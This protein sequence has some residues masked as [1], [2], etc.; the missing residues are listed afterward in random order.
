MLTYWGNPETGEGV[1]AG[2]VWNTVN[3]YLFTA[4]DMADDVFGVINA[5][6]GQIAQITIEG[7]ADSI[8]GGQGDQFNNT[9]DGSVTVGDN[10]ADTGFDTGKDGDYTGNYQIRVT[11]LDGTVAETVVSLTQEQFEYLNGLL[12]DADGNSRL[13]EKEVAYQ[14]QA[15][16]AEG[17]PMVDADGNPILIDAVVEGDTI[18][19]NHPIILTPTQN[20]GGTEEIGK[21]SAADDFIVAGRLDLLHGAYIDGGEGNNTLEIDA[22]GYYAQPKELLNI[23]TINIENLPNVYTNDSGDSTYP[24]L[25]GNG[26]NDSTI[27]LSRA[28]DLEKLTITESDFDGVNEAELGTLTIAG[29]RNGA[30]TRFEGEFSQ[31][32]TVHY[33]E[34]LT[35]ALNIEL[36]IGDVNADINLLHNASTLNIDSQGTENHMHQFFAGGTLSH[37]NISGEAIFSVEENMAAGFNTDRPAVI[38]ASANTGGVDLTIDGHADEVIFTGTAE[39]DDQFQA[40]SNGKAVTINGGNGDN[41]FSATSGDVVTITAGSGNNTITTDDSDT[42][43]ITTGE[44]NDVI[45]SV[46]GE[47]VS[48]NAA[49]GDNSITVSADE[50][51]ITTGEGNDT[52][53]ISG[54][55]DTTG[56]NADGN[57]AALVNIDTGTGEDTVVLGRDLASF[58]FGI[59]A[60][61]GSSISGEN[62]TLYVENASDLRAAELSGVENVVLNFDVDGGILTLTDAQFAAIGA[63]NFAVEGAPFYTSAQVKIIVTESTSLTDLGVD[64]LPVGVDLILEIQDGVTLEMTAEQLHT[65]VAEQ[66]VTLANDNNGDQQS[67]SVLITNAGLDFDPFNS[68]DDARSIVDGVALSGGSL[69]SDF[70]EDGNDSNTTVDRNEWGQNVLI[71][72]NMNGYDRPADVP[73]YS[74]L[75][76]NTDE[77]S[78][79]GPFETIETFLRITGESDL[80]FTPVEGGVDDWGRPIE[81]GSAIALGVDNGV[82]TNGFIVD[83]SSVGGVVNNLTLSG[84]ENADAI[85]GNGARVNVELT[86][87]VGDDGTA[88]N[89]EGGLVSSG[90]HTYVVT[91]M[92]DGDREFWTCETTKDLETLGLRGNDNTTITFGNTERG[93][94]FLMEVVYDKQDGYAVGGL[95]AN[96]ARPEG[97]TAVVNVVGLDTLPAGEVQQV[98]GISTDATAAI[99]NIEGGNTVVESLSGANLTDLAVSAD[100]NLTIAGDLP[101]GLTSFDASGV[102]GDLAVT[103]DLWEAN[104]TPLTFE[105]AAGSTTLTIDDAADGAIASIMGAGEIALVIGD[106]NGSDSADL[107]G[108]ELSNITSVSLSENAQL[109]LTLDQAYTIGAENFSGEGSLTLTELNDQPFSRAD[110]E[111]DVTN[112]TLRVVEQSDVTLNSATDLTGITTLEVYEGTTLNLTAA[113]FQ[114]LNGSNGGIITVLDGSDEGTAVDLSTVTINITDLSQADLENGVLDT[115]AIT[116][117][118]INITTAESV[119]LV[120]ATNL[121]GVD[122]ITLADGTTLSVEALEE[123]DGIDVAGIDAIIKIL[124]ETIGATTSIDASGFD[125]SQIYLANT[126]LQNGVNV[127]ALLAG[128]PFTVEKVIFNGEGL[129]IEGDQTVTVEAQTTVVGNL[130]FNKLALD[131]E[132]QNFTLNLEGGVE[133]QD[134]DLSSAIKT[135]ADG[136]P[137]LNTHLETVV[138]N[139]NKSVDAD[140][141][142]LANLMSGETANVIGTLTAAGT[143]ASQGSTN[144]TDNSGY[145]DDSEENNLLDVTIN[146]T[147]D[148]R[149]DGIVFSAVNGDDAWGINDQDAA[150]ATVEITGTADVALGLLDTTDDDVDALTVNNSGT[151]TVSATIDGSATGFDADDALSFTGS[152]IALTVEG[153]VDLSDDDLS[154][155]SAVT[156]ADD[157]ALTLSFTQL[158]ALGAENVV[159]TEGTLTEDLTINGYDGSAFDFTTIDENIDE[160]ALV[161]DGSDVVLDATVNL[162]GVVSIDA[163]GGTLTLTAAQFNQLA[164][165]GTITNATALNITDLTQD[166]VDAGFDITGVASGLADPTAITITLGEDRVDLGTFEGGQLVAN[167][168]ADL[169]A[170]GLTNDPSASFLLADGQTLGLVNITQANGLV[171]NSEAGAD[172]T[173]VYM[174]DTVPPYL[175]DYPDFVIDASGY[176]VS[177]LKAL[178]TMVDGTNIEA[179]LYELSS[180][181]TLQ[182]YHDPEQL[183]LLNPTYRVVTVEEGVTVDGFLM[184]NDPDTNDEVQ[185]L[186][187]NL[188]GGT[189]IDGDIILSTRDNKD[190]TAEEKFLQT[191]T[192]I[193]EGTAENLQ[194]ANNGNT[195]VVANRISGAIDGRDGFATDGAENNVLNVN[196]TATQ[197]LIIADDAQGT[198]DGIYFT[199]VESGATARL[200]ITEESTADVTIERLDVSDDEV[201]ALVVTNDGTGALTITGASA[202][203]SGDVKTITLEG[204]STGSMY[205]GT[206]EAIEDLQDGIDGDDVLSAIDASGLAGM[207]TIEN[208][209][210]VDANLFAFTSGTGETNVTFHGLTVNADADPATASGTTLD[211]SN[212]AAGSEVH[213]GTNI[214]TN[215]SLTIDLGANTT[216]YIDQNTDWSNLDSLTINQTNAIVLADGVTLTLTA[217]QANTLNIVEATD[218]TAT[219][220][221]VDLSTEEVHLE[222]INVTNMVATLKTVSGTDATFADVLLDPNTDLGEFTIKLF[223]LG[224]DFSAGQN[225]RF[226]TAEQAERTIDVVEVGGN[227]TD[228]VNVVWYFDTITG[229]VEVADQIDVSGYSADIGR[230]WITEVLAND[231]NFAEIMNKLPESIIRI[232]FPADMGFAVPGLDTAE[233]FTRR[234]EVV[235]F[236]NV[237]QGFEFSDLDALNYVENLVLTLGGEVNLGNLVLND[238]MGGN[239]DPDTV[240]FDTLTINSELAEDDSNDPLLPDEW[241]DDG[242]APDNVLPTGNNVIGDISSG[243]NLELLNVTINASEVGLEV[244]TIYF[245]A[246]TAGSTANLVVTGSEDVTI[247]SLDTIDPEVNAVVNIDATQHNGVLTVTGGSPAA[248]LNDVETLNINTGVDDNQPDPETFDSD[249]YLGHVAGEAEGEYVLN[250]DGNG[251][252]YAGVAG[253]ELSAIT[254]TGDGDVNL[255]VLA[256]IDGTDDDSASDAFTLNGGTGTGTVTAILGEGNVDGVVTSPLLEDGSTWRFVNVDLTIQETTDPMFEAGAILEVDGGSLTIEGEVDLTEV[257]LDLTNVTIDVP[258]DQTLI[259]TV[260]QVAELAADGVEVVGSGTV[261]VI[262][263]GDDATAS[264]FGQLRTA[265][266][267]MSAVVLTE[268]DAND[269][270]AATFISGEDD[271]GEVIGQTITG[272]TGFANEIL[273]GEDDDTLIG[274][275]G[276]DTLYG[277]GGSDTF[278]ITAGSDIVMDLR[279]EADDEDEN[280]TEEQ[281]V[282]IVSSGASVTADDIVEFVA[283]AETIN[284]G[285]AALTGHSGDSTIDVSL[286]GGSNGFTLNGGESGANVLTGSANDDIIDGGDSVQNGADVLTGNGGEDTFHF[287]VGTSTPAAMSYTTPQANVD[288]ELITVTT[289]AVT[290]AGSITI[291]YTLNGSPNTN[292]LEVVLAES[293][294]PELVAGKIASAFNGVNGFTAIPVNEVVTVNNADGA[295]FTINTVTDSGGTGVV[296]SI[297]DGTDQPQ[298]TVVTI[299]TADTDTVVAGEKYIVELDPV[300]PGTA[301]TF[302]YEAGANETVANVLANLASAI[303]GNVEFSAT[304]N[305]NELTIEDAIPN[306]GGFTVVLDTEGGF[307]GSG[308]SVDGA[309]GDS[310][311]DAQADLITDFISGE[312][313]IDLD[314]VA[315]TATNFLAE[316]EVADYETA[317]VNANNAMDGVVRYYL[318]SLADNDATAEVDDATGLLFFDAN[319]DGTVDGVIAL[320]GI[321]E[322]NFVFGDIVA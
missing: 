219:V 170:D 35:G 15:T 10:D 137:L 305:G 171:V 165:T 44:G 99:I 193:S 223:G 53:V 225:I 276:D 284:N 26:S 239:T 315:G 114:Q 154:G 311:V 290:Q 278:E 195:G 56:L 177:T 181:V 198:A 299:G 55:T 252:P 268:D 112:L 316:A 214:Y 9:G 295:S 211:F 91:D 167:S 166:D 113:Q 50:M 149:M 310:I 188:L 265:N 277:R 232:E 19:T 116:A 133:L 246:D 7:A 14:V 87:N 127:D 58:D 212:A 280:T 172:T 255:G 226:S 164:G 191:I 126:L 141:Q 1:P 274:G 148:L 130:E 67:G 106:G 248:A 11:L 128:L 155:V 38:D 216:L 108:T 85:Y 27:D 300:G 270:F 235:A 287:V 264:I 132:V 25:S 84:F 156:L 234:I 23:Q 60:L 89:A 138:I 160:V 220:E 62:I 294:T 69:S 301:T 183:G 267:D 32:V 313:V 318:T 209:S 303:D 139:S 201:D 122:T 121:T 152:S 288:R 135:D 57:W 304:V 8:Q 189:H 307:E 29:V 213:L 238:Q 24:D 215:G 71:D 157:A 227:G 75:V 18:V 196:I 134:V 308:A 103:V 98:Q 217:E 241:E 237:D 271:T 2:Q 88:T 76:I 131:T 319:E 273:A 289:G 34:G 74:R 259:L 190:G 263:N 20:N 31:D 64:N 72:R 45:S 101:S 92:N 197:D 68:S 129:V 144:D 143:L 161:L 297:A 208:V 70:G 312:D 322:N 285:T 80:T 187:L 266:V 281:D 63:E 222:D 221:V 52:I 282:L 46:R 292:N 49:G 302:T 107:T 30:L 163:N 95:V 233:G 28:V 194:D 73:S 54:M 176:K 199:S 159:G 79:I 173:L 262:G 16:D 115:S 269:V 81:G 37:L 12:F 279:S 3:A 261:E 124:D 317:L 275:T 178:N 244:G 247:K 242:I 153:T 174:F 145:E 184:F 256:L 231:A 59:V 93:V 104:E 206:A 185:S 39:A 118:N 13:F 283:T 90:V 78:E 43:S 111:V 48:I 83:F 110:F 169:D 249:V 210:N 192:I 250:L 40:N 286:A 100:A 293:D 42:V 240:T 22:K 258:A 146:A 291:V 102:A 314:L 260:A 200:T 125:V 182:I 17:T 86:G 162:T 97:A 207:L 254:I 65:R 51:N 120:D 306:N 229:D 175:F 105:G 123:L 117:A 243:A 119:T 77:M 204:A 205:F 140:N 179:L 309:L 224:D 61:E 94:D 296:A 203:V 66:G 96:F 6:L 236:S 82:A 245:D 257:T 151:G 321:D 230:L 109:A 147:Q 272:S 202:S 168:E 142:D 33:G 21:T 150:A 41:E 36:A 320:T 251:V 158:T 186:T 218:A 228:G 5:S 136:N 4:A 47:T 298:Q 180:D 253:A